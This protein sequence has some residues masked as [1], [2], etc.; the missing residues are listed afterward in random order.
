MYHDQNLKRVLYTLIYAHSNVVWY[1]L[2]S[3]APPSQNRNPKHE[4][5]NLYQRT[6]DYHPINHHCWTPTLYTFVPNVWLWISQVP[7]PYLWTS[8]SSSCHRSFHIMFIWNTFCISF[9]G[10][11]I[12]SWPFPCFKD[13]PGSP[14][15]DHLA[16]KLPGPIAIHIIC[17]A[18][19]L[20]MSPGT[21]QILWLEVLALTYGKKNNWLVVEPPLWK[22]EEYEFVNWDDEI[23]NIWKTCS[24]PPTHG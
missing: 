8:T 24:K 10:F 2:C 12:S 18:V 22:I 7:W 20:C 17:S 4:H 6:N 1:I 21:L 15:G 19:L 23:P 3:M 11:S 5:V 16:P 13:I 14:G 9:L